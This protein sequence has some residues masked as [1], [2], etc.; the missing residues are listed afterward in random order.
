M[1]ECMLSHSVVSSSLPPLDCSPSGFSVHGILQ[2]RILIPGYF[3][4]MEIKA[5]SPVSPALQVD[6]LLLR[7]L[8]SHLATICCRYSVAKSCPL[9]CNSMSCITPGFPVL[10]Y[11]REF[12]QTHIHRVYDAIQTSHP[13]S[14]P[15]PPALY[16][17]QHHGLFQWV[18]SSH[19]VAK[20]LKFQLKQQSFQWILRVDWIDLL[21]VHGTLK[22]IL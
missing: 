14:S 22:I 20:I 4:D 12:A 17:S 18:G 3:H 15:S 7:N 8:G 19:Q 10:H 9:L 13:L 21:S 16:L 5:T 11:L 6:S 1:P 2:A